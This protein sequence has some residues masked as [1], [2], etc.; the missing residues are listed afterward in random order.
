M[1]EIC[2]YL[3][4]TYMSNLKNQSK[5]EIICNNRNKTH[6][7][8]ISHNNDFFKNRKKDKISFQIAFRNKEICRTC[9]EDNYNNILKDISDLKMDRERL[10]F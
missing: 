4:I 6:H 5:T 3:Q 2:N 8:L 7:I 9:N 10:G 1:D